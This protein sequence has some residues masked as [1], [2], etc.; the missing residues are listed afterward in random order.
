MQVAKNKVVSIDYTLTDD[1]GQEL[2]TSAGAAP[3]VYLHGVGAVIPG[4]ERAL[5]G[6]SAGDAVT[7]VIPPAE[8]YGAHDDALVQSLPRSMFGGPGQ[9]VRV[10]MAFRGRTESG[11]HEVK[12]V[13]VDADT[14]T[15]DANHALAGQTLHFDIK[16]VDVRDATP[17]EIAHG[18]AHGPGGHAH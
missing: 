7:A 6:R 3:L 1:A 9:D 14:V 4:L 16:V 11:D 15:I 12:V 5:E 17:E 10:G 13:A 2:D 8:A 18:H